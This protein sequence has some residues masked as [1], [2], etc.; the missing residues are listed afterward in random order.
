MLDLP[1]SARGDELDFFYVSGGFEPIG[2][3][4]Q[5]VGFQCPHV[6]GQP[7]TAF[8]S[9]VNATLYDHCTENMH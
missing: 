4:S 7:R 1:D 8:D 3:D 6:F 5:V 9:V 2:E